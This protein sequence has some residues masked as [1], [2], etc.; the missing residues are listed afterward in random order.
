VTVAFT[1]PMADVTD[2]GAGHVIFGGSVGS[3]VGVG[4]VGFDFV[5]AT[6]INAGSTEAGNTRRR[7]TL[8]GKLN[9]LW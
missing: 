9:F 6:T 4:D 1:W 8:N 3:G 7:R 5:H 2:C